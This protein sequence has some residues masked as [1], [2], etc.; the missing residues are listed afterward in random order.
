M[1]VM[2]GGHDQYTRFKGDPT[3]YGIKKKIR[4]SA[5]AKL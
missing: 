2:L 1:V 5:S 3:S 4:V